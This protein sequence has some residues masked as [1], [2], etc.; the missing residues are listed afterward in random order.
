MSEIRPDP[1]TPGGFRVSGELVFDTVPG[2]L[3]SGR[4]L[5][6]AGAGDV[7]IDLGGVTRADSA[8]LAL[9]VEWARAAR[10]VNRRLALRNMPDKMAAMAG[11]SGLDTVLPI[12]RRPTP[13]D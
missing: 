8:G 4:A 1:A 11:I 7:I 12:D 10:R 9:L 2:L 5:L 6:V 13:Q 3:A